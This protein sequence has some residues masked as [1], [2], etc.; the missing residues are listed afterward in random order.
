ML[1]VILLGSGCA[2]NPL[3]GPM[4]TAL[5]R[6]IGPYCERKLAEDLAAGSVTPAFV[7]AK[8]LE[9]QALRELVKEARGRG[10]E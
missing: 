9:L 1:T 6:T 7:K 8:R 4:D 5:N 10:D 2:T 3:L